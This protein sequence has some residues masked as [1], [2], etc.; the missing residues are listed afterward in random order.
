MSNVLKIGWCFNNIKGSA[1]FSEP[2]PMSKYIAQRNTINSVNTCPA[3]LDFNSRVFT[4]LSPY[5]FRIRAI[6]NKN[7]DYDFFPIYP[8]TEVM[9]GLIQKE[10]T[11]QPKSLWRDKKYPV[12][13]LALPY[14]F[15]ANECTF[16]NQ[17]EPNRFS[18]KKNW[19][20]IQG[21]FDISSWQRPVNWAIEWTNL[22]ADLVIK[23]GDPLCQ[24][25]FESNH[26]AR[27]LNLEYFEKDEY[28]ETAIARTVGVTHKIRGTRKIMNNN[29]LF[30][31]NYEKLNEKN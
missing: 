9:D 23:K 17:V 18:S 15:F 11:F 24:L 3:A 14:V 21:R 7:G 20:L 5:S 30:Q 6:S 1:I 28:L 8:E 22:K 31:F 26:P 25:I 12:L 10:I 4:I 27:K 2:L 19:S 13:Q 16:I 29:D